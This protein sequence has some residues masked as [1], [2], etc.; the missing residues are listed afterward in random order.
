LIIK[1][2]YILSFYTIFERGGILRDLLKGFP[3]QLNEA[4][5][6]GKDIKV[7]G[8]ITNILVC[9]MG[10]SA[11]PGDLLKD[12]IGDDIHVHVNKGYDVPNWV[13]KETLA[14]VISYS[15][16]TEETIASFFKLRKKRVNIVVIT[17]GGKLKRLCEDDNVPL[18]EVPSGIP[19]R[20]AV[21]YLFIPILMVLQNNKLIQDSNKE[22][23][24]TISSLRKFDDNFAK[25]L[26]ISLYKRLP[27]IYA[28]DKYSG[29]VT[30]W[31]NQFNEDSKILALSN[32]FSELDHN[33][34]EGFSK[35]SE[36]YKVIILR[37]KDDYVR[38]KKR[39]S[40]TEVIIGK[41]NYIELWLQGKSKLEKLLYGIHVGDWVSYYLANL[42]G[43][44]PLEV[45]KIDYLK[46]K[47]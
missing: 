10:G 32:V 40:I 24:K 19:P 15:G 21:A 25:H 29:L 16:D 34:I 5:Y 6:M 20:G 2:F 36:N 28:S 41:K 13:N 46:S 4:M 9:G 11:I 22:L 18:I 38:I 42:E 37:D 47:L 35:L 43:I 27:I 1:K 3:S 30:R 33:E 45:K 17:S 44:D 7:K 39:M 14:F 12:Y 26:A 23:K 31:K 8:K